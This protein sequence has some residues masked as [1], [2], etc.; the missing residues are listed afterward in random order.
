MPVSQVKTNTISITEFPKDG[1]FWIV[2][3]LGAVEKNPTIESEP[4]FEVT[5]SPF[6]NNSDIHLPPNKIVSKDVISYDEQQSIQV[7]VGQLP[8]V[9][10]GSI[11]L[12]GER[13]LQEA[14]SE[15]AYYDIEISEETTQTIFASH[16][17]K[18]SAL[19]PYNFYRYGSGNKNAQ[20]MAIKYENDP[21]GIL[22][23]MMELARFYYTVSTDLAQTIF[24][25]AL[26]HN[27]SSVVNTERTGLIT[28]EKRC[29]IGLRQHYSN[30]D[31]WVLG[32]IFYDKN[33]WKG[34]TL[35]HDDMM[36]H[37][38]NKE[39]THIRS[40]FPFAGA[41]NLRVRAKPIKCYADDSWRSLVLSIEQCTAPFPFEYLTADRDNNAKKADP[42]SDIPDNQKKP[43][44]PKPPPPKPKNGDKP[45]QSKQAPS[46]HNQAE[47]LSLPSQRFAALMG[48]EVDMPEKEQC[49]YI[50][51]RFNDDKAKKTNKLG[52]GKGTSGES[53]TGKGSVNVKHVR[54]EALPASFDVFKNAIIELNRKDGIQALIRNLDTRNTIIPLTGPSHKRQWSYLNSDELSRRQ[55][56]AADIKTNNQIFT[57]VEV[58]GRPNQTLKVALLSKVDKS[59]I[60]ENELHIL[61]LKLAYLKGV[62]DNMNNTSIEDLQI[63]TMKHTWPT[64]QDFSNSILLRIN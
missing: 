18:E 55:I 1:R 27:I 38:I 47:T 56:I 19:I 52:T 60:N 64:A 31:G 25:G 22:I 4:T 16:R 54:R 53:N 9:N 61:L 48:K 14:G 3:W 17:I 51:K 11:W 33:A 6:H 15:K 24:S 34:A 63:S 50:S 2:D 45:F 59:K 26:Q 46:K 58:Q 57:L 39:P 21:L 23:P 7:G 20:L 29:V 28:D 35:P 41:T 37:A 8:L 36:K 10:I 32:R 30:E 12:D 42:D 62:W 49:N 43:A 5:I 44:F 40:C 13:Q